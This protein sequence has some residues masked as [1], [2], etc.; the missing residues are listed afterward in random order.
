VPAGCGSSSPK[1]SG[2]STTPVPTASVRALDACQLLRLSDVTPLI[3][4]AKLNSPTGGR[5]AY[6]APAKTITT[7]S[8]TGTA[9]SYV[10]PSASV[11]IV[12]HPF[13]NIRQSDANNHLAPVAVSGVGDAA[14][15]TTFHGS[16]G[17]YDSRGLTA[18]VGN[19]VISVRV[20]LGGQ[21]PGADLAA[22]RR[23]A[24]LVVARVRSTG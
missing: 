23:L 16:S 13:A 9:I 10:Y 18:T 21:N 8:G 11:E 1:A 22:C 19:V 5:C 7:Q 4:K 17:R 24:L 14:Y 2:P 15:A 12:D 3:P 6:V 20:S